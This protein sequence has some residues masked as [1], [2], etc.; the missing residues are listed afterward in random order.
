MNRVGIIVALRAE[1]RCITQQRIPF[2]QA[3][4]LDESLV[5]RICGMGGVAAR[6]AATALCEQEKVTRL[7]SFGVAGALDDSLQPGDLILPKSVLADRNYPADDG[8]RTRV[9]RCLPGRIN[10]IQCSLV[11]SDTVITTETAKRML[12]SQ[13]GG[14]AVD[15]E[16]G[17]V[18]AV[19]AEKGVL[20]LAIRA[21]SDPVQFSPP[22]A[23][24]DV[25]HPDGRVKPIALLAYL[26]N[27]SLKLGELLRFG[28]DAQIAFKTLKQVV[29]ATRHELGRQV[30]GTC[31]GISD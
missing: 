26:L 11:T 7:I 29:Q 1:A 13:S 9:Q 17:A 30:S 20:F 4:V 5:I 14:C 10:V 25:L 27:G 16:S 2:D 6:R 21:I 12:A 18:A 19:A 3:I 24:M 22:A 31:Q 23:L 15:M 8:W 28:S